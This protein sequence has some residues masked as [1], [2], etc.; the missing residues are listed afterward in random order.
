[1]PNANWTNSLFWAAGGDQAFVSQ[2]VCG[3][4][5]TFTGNK[6]TSTYINIGDQDWTFWNTQPRIDILVQVYGDENL[7]I[8]TTASNIRVWRF[9]L[10]GSGVLGVNCTGTQSKTVNGAAVSTNNLPNFK[11]NW[12]LFRSPMSRLSFAPQTPATA[13]WEA[14]F[15]G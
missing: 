3:P 13:G 2:Q 14:S 4:L 10:A 7:M 5:V 8:N 6:A 1:M 11:W 9:Q 15:P 12:L